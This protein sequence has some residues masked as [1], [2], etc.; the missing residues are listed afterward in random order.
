MFIFSADKQ[1]LFALIYIFYFTYFNLL[2]LTL[3]KKVYLNYNNN[4][5]IYIYLYIYKYL[6]K[7]K[8]KITIKQKLIAFT[9]HWL[10]GASDV[11]GAPGRRRAR[12]GISGAGTLGATPEDEGNINL[13]SNAMNLS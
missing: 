8:K 4:I 2:K 12:V 5:Y 7:L 1:S 11:D 9:G 13:G 6:N 10:G 3:K